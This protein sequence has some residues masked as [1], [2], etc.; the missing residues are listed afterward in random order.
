MSS[1]ER[2]ILVLGMTWAGMSGCA[3][4]GTPKGSRATYPS[5]YTVPRD[6]SAEVSKR[7]SSA[8]LN[9]R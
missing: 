3:S 2:L 5:S 6:T 8:R 4:S 7:R 1:K 9:P